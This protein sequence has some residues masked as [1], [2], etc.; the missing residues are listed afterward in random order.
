MKTLRSILTALLWSLACQLA[1]AVDLAT[2]QGVSFAQ[3]SYSDDPTRANTPIGVM[4]VDLNVLRN[5]TGISS[6]DINLATATGW[7]V[8]NLPVFAENVYP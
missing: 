6:G 8:R 2:G 1:W 4:A 3:T 7:V 5:S